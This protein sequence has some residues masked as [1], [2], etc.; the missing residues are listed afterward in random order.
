MSLVILWFFDTFSGHILQN[1]WN[2]LYY[3]S[4][5]IAGLSFVWSIVYVGEMIRQFLI[6]KRFLKPTFPG[7]DWS[8]SG[9]LG[10]AVFGNTAI[11]STVLVINTPIIYKIFFTSSV[12]AASLYV[13]PLRLSLSFRRLYRFYRQQSSHKWIWWIPLFAFGSR[14][15]ATVLPI[16]GTEQLHNTLPF[17]KYVFRG[18]DFNQFDLDTHF[19]LLGTYES[20]GVFI[21][22]F[23]LNDFSYHIVSQQVTFLFTVGSMLLFLGTIPWVLRKLPALAVGL[24]AWPAMLNFASTDAIAFKPDWIGILAAAAATVA[25]L[26]QYLSPSPSVQ[27][28]S[29]ISVVIFSSF[30]VTAKLTALP[31]VIF[32]LPSSLVLSMVQNKKVQYWHWM[33]PFL[34]LLL[35][36][37]FFGKNTIW[38]GNPVFPGFQQILPKPARLADTTNFNTFQINKNTQKKPEL[39]DY[40]SGYLRFWKHHPEFLVSVFVLLLLIKRK[41]RSKVALTCL[42]FLFVYLTLM[43]FYFY[44]G[45]YQ[46]YVAFA[47]IFLLIFTVFVFMEIDHFSQS[48]WK[49]RFVGVFIFL[50]LTHAQVDANFRKAL[51]AWGQGVSPKEFRISQDS[52]DQI[53]FEINSRCSQVGR[54][55]NNKWRN[56]YYADFDAVNL[57]DLMG[58]GALYKSDF[59]DKYNVNFVI[60]PDAGPKYDHLKESTE[61]WFKENFSLVYRAKGILLWQRNTFKNCHH[62]F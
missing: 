41:R 22:A 60:T 52:V 57:E 20:F 25:L 37:P 28:A 54:L 29:M 14:Y 30:A 44:P 19:L 40:L 51:P 7:M 21:R 2:R 45:I 48:K 17:A 56:Y 49:N 43:S 34:F 13:E 50:M 18:I 59:Y 27:K 3:F 36:L 6:K 11:V 58:W 12:A 16:N 31:Y 26:R 10:L 42:A 8:I 61:V 46:R 15:L 32:L 53:Y 33:M 5:M 1:Q 4:T 39:I 62:P 38:L 55:F 23:L 24:A 35:C 9:L 47:Y